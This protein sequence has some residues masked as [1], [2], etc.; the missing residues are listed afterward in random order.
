MFVLELGRTSSMSRL[1]AEDYVRGS[2]MCL[3]VVKGRGEVGGCVS[4]VEG[5]GYPKVVGFLQK[6]G[7]VRCVWWKRAGANVDPLEQCHG[8]NEAG[9]KTSALLCYGA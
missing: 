9:S 3:C 1:K 5:G 7:A 6:K 2:H 8:C 4:G